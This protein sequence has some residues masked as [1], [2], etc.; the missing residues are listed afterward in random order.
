MASSVSFELEGCKARFSPSAVASE[1]RGALGSLSPANVT[2]HPVL[3]IPRGFLCHYK[4]QLALIG[5]HSQAN[6]GISSAD[7]ESLEMM[8]NPS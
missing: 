8:V 1:I 5:L 4:A 2:G 3:H 7:G 6:V